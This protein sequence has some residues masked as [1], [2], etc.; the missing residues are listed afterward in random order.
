MPSRVQVCNM[1]LGLIGAEPITSLTADTETSRKCNLYLDQTIEEVLRAYPW[2]CAIKLATLAQLDETP[3]MKYDYAYSLPAD[4]LRA[5][6]GEYS[7]IK[8]K[9]TGAKLLC[10]ESSMSLE[11]ISL[12]GVNEMD[13]LCRAAVIVKL[14]AY[15]AFAVTNSSTMQD[16]MENLYEKAL[17]KAAIAD[18][19]E[20]TPDDIDV[21]DFLNARY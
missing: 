2:N 8:F 12:I 10:N 3:A 9:I 19:Q 16:K 6:W 5:L 4:C 1:S 18:A 15:L 13:S 14:A 7:D 11:Y 17:L 21:E 20:G